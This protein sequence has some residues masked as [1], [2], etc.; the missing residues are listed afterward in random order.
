MS[1][2]SCVSFRAK[3][4]NSRKSIS[5]CSVSRAQFFSTSTLTRHR[6]QMLDRKSSGA[7]DTFITARIVL[8]SVTCSS[9]PDLGNISARRP[10]RKHSRQLDTCTVS[11]FQFR[12]QHGSW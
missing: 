7:S 8:L 5:C 6:S 2:S 12:K 11:P 1:A 3:F 9:L 10:I 4:I